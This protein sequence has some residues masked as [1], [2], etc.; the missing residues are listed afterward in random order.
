MAAL[1]GPAEPCLPH[2][3]QDKRL[4][5]FQ[6]AWLLKCLIRRLDQFTA[7]FS[8]QLVAAQVALAQ[9]QYQ[10]PRLT[11]MWSHLERQAGGKSRG[12]G[13]KQLEVDKRLMRTRI[14]QLQVATHAYSAC[15]L[16]SDTPTEVRGHACASS[17]LQRPPGT[18]VQ[19][20]EVT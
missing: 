7:S 20:L 14:G 6:P 16:H 18:L 5:L 17:A 1:P 4:H 10:L 19:Q 2:T 12:M 13:E 9:L 15:S 8:P 3:S 11:R